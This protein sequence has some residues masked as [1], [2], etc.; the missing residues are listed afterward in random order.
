MRS[1]SRGTLR[2]DAVYNLVPAD[3]REQPAVV[4]ANKI[5]KRSNTPFCA[6]LTNSSSPTE[7]R[8]SLV[9]PRTPR[10]I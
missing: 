10:S 6:R 7:P 1:A 5:T 3:R 2:P 4:R 9:S 8:R